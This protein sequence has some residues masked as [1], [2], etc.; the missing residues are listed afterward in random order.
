[1]IGHHWSNSK[2]KWIPFSEMSGPHAV[3][4]WKKLARLDS[5][6]TEDERKANMEALAAE[7]R[8]RGA[9]LTDEGWKWPEVPAASES[10]FSS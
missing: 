3:N 1:M 10:E 4:A 6:L 2:Q 5:D 8:S 7:L 9:T